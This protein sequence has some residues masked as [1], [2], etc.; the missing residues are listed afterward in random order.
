MPVE[1]IP[2]KQWF[3]NLLDKKDILLQQNDKMQWHPEFM[4]KRS[5]DWIENLQRD[6]NVS[7]SRKYGIPIPV[8]YSKSGEIILP[9][10]EQLS[11]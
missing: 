8:R 11:K 4:Q 1:I 2:I 9:R 7:R 3:V 6:R 10:E 5:N